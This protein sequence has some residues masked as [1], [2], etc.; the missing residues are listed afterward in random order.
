MSQRELSRSYR[1]WVARE[2]DL[3]RRL[4]KLE[5]ATMA[6][7][8]FV[9]GIGPVELRSDVRH[10]RKEAGWMVQ[11]LQSALEYCFKQRSSLKLK[12]EHGRPLHQVTPPSLL[13]L[14]F[15]LPVIPDPPISSVYVL[16]VPKFFQALD[17]PPTYHEEADEGEISL[18]RSLLR[19]I[20]PRG[21]GGEGRS[22]LRAITPT[23][24]LPRW[25]A[26]A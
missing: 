11:R 24:F 17:V 16:C 21:A 19:A 4:Q 2:N 25:S 5:S 7:R 13:S 14:G 15:P 3:I 12:D 18:G 9:E 6:G 20:T 23:A 1:L 26:R 22:L 8:T 10:A